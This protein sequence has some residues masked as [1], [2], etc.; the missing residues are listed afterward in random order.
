[1]RP[2]APEGSRTRQTRLRK[3]QTHASHRTAPMGWK[4][5]ATAS[6][7]R[8][9]GRRSGAATPRGA[10]CAA[11]SRRRR[12]RR[13]VDPIYSNNDSTPIPAIA[14]WYSATWLRT[15]WGHF[16]CHL[17]LCVAA[18]HGERWSEEQSNCQ[19][20]RHGVMRTLIPHRINSWFLITQTLILK[21][22]FYLVSPLH[23]ADERCLS[24]R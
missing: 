9:R 13:R 10:G 12:R 17:D 3:R 1:M 4:R 14:T 23:M 15:F 24:C 19:M 2:A 5:R 18:W 7:F 22:V 20:A 16:N 21:D 11:A 8:R 6:R